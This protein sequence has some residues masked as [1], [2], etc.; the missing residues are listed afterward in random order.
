MAADVYVAT[1]SA[2]IT[3][4]E[5]PAYLQAGV[6]TARDGHPILVAYPQFWRLLVPDFDVAVPVKAAEPAKAEE[7]A[8]AVPPV[9]PVRADQ[10]GARSRSA[11]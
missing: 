11:S 6:S 2:V 10:A 8:K 9:S 7:P 5:G 4:A 3:T 1:E